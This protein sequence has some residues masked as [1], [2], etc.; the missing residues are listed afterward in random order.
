M[1]PVSTAVGG[2]PTRVASELPAVRA[3]RVKS[4]SW[5]DGRLVAGIVLVLLSVVVGAKVLASADH[6]D[7]VWAASRD[8][9]PGTTLTASD[10]I[11]VRVRFHDHGGGYYSASSGSLVGRTTTVPLQAGDLIGTDAVPPKT[12]APTRLVTVPVDKLHM[13]RGDLRGIQVDLYVT[14]RH[15]AGQDVQARPQLVL[16]GVTVS[17][18]VAD[19]GLGSNGSGLVLAVPSPYV[20]AVVAAAESG[21]LDVVRVPAG[22]VAEPSPGPF[23]ASA[24]AAAGTPALAATPSAGT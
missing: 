22:S 4:P 10:V 21:A 16:A 13:P 24:G 12:P 11:V 6:Y 7:E 14:V 5:L 18:T 1:T 20:H 17:D 23:V 8:L 3:R 2:S 15:N 19:S 9:A